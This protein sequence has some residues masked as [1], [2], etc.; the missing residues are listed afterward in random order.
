MYHIRDIDN[1]CIRV[2]KITLNLTENIIDFDIVH[3]ITLENI[4][5]IRISFQRRDGLWHMTA[6][7]KWVDQNLGTMPLS[8]IKARLVKVAENVLNN[9][10]EFS[11]IR[12]SNVK[13]T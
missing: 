11:K 9:H 1:G 10:K 13:R 4:S 12:G 7:S 8:I 3:D 2:N 5:V 6:K